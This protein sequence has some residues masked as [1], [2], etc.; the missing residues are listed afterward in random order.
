MF[1]IF[2]Y[3]CCSFGCPSRKVSTI[4]GS[5]P[6][7]N[8]LATN[9]APVA[10]VEVVAAWIK[11]LLK[12]FAPPPCNNISLFNALFAEF[13]LTSF[14]LELLLLLLK[15]LLMVLLLLLFVVVPL[16][17]IGLGIPA[18]AEWMTRENR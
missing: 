2:K 3:A 11:G 6:F 13:V 8:T 15:L 4:P 14:P 17:G 16:A 1:T 10:G 9:L 5:P 7:S 18:L 12:L